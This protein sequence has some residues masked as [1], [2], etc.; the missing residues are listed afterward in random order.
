MNEPITGVRGRGAVA[1]T[2]WVN[3][4]TGTDI[5]CRLPSL[6]EINDSAV[7]RAL[8]LSTPGTQTHSVW[9]EPESG[10]DQPRLWTPAGKAHPYTI[11]A[12]TL[13]SHVNDDIDH[14]IPT[15]TQLL[16]LR[17]SAAARIL[18]RARDLNL[19]PDLVFGLAR[20]LNR[21]RALNRALNRALALDLALDLAFDLVFDLAGGRDLQ[22]RRALDRDLHLPRDL[23]RALDLAFDRDRA[24]DRALDL[25][26][27]R[28]RGLDRDLALDLD[29]VTG[30]GLSQVLTR[31]YRTTLAT[32]PTDFSQAFV[33]VTG[34]N[35][36]KYIVSPDTLVD[37]VHSGREALF[38]IIRPP[39]G[40]V[41][42]RRFSYPSH[43]W[44]YRVVSNFEK[45]ALPI[46]IRQHSFTS[47]TATA[48]RITALCLAV[49]ADTRGAH[50]VGN[51]FREIAA[52]VTLLERRLNHQT[53]PTETIL[54]AIT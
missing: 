23:D 20:D 32:W 26:F 44:A 41:K 30:S 17:S 36:T 3:V 12:S 22:L 42:S 6:A 46:F 52:G 14:S 24:L 19:A 37:K 49:E 40:N 7:Q 15:L 29:R 35:D 48:L 11:D 4:I 27:A 8:T 10:H 31:T 13:I 43:S 54:L 28:A 9:L 33:E 50:P 51:T 47:D 38:E 45:M 53:L 34:I 2:R 16:L 5:V 1:F 18:A 25:G 21:A 39:E